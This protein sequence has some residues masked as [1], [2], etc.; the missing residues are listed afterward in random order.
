MSA[1]TR[2]NPSVASVANLNTCRRI[3]GSIRTA[4][5]SGTRTIRREI[6]GTRSPERR[7]R[8]KV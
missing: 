5:V 1:A 2:G 8:M 3:A 6:M 4:N 7:K